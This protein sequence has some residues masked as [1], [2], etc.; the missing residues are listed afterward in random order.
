MKTTKQN[1]AKNLKQSVIK[2]LKENPDVNSKKFAKDSG[3]K[4]QQIAAFKAHITMK[5]Y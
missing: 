3:Y 5:T 2:F 4:P 1:F